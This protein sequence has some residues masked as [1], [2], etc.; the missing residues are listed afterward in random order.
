MQPVG[1]HGPKREFLCRPFLLDGSL[2]VYPHRDVR[3][4]VPEKFLSR[5]DV[6]LQFSKHRC[7]YGDYK[8]RAGEAEVV[9]QREVAPI[10][11]EVSCSER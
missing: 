6:D 4:G 3:V 7:E 11:V 5:L 10:L 9:R 2:L 1:K 8:V